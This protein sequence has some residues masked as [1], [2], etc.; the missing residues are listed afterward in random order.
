M[1]TLEKEKDEV[2]SEIT[3][4]LVGISNNIKT[5][6]EKI[7]ECSLIDQNVLILGETGTGK[8]IV[9]QQ[10]HQQSKRYD[11]EL[12]AV[13]VP[14]LPPDLIESELFGSEKGGYTGA[15]KDKAGLLQVANN[16]T[17]FL[18]EIGD[19]PKDLQ[20]KLLRPIEQKEFYPIGSSTPVE[21][22]FRVISAT[23]QSP[24]KLRRD[25]Y[26]RLAERTI[27]IL[28]LK[29]RRDDILPLIEHFLTMMGKEFNI[30]NTYWIDLHVLLMNPWNGNVRELKTLC[31]NVKEE[32]LG[33]ERVLSFDILPLSIPFDNDKY[34]LPPPID[35]LDPKLDPKDVLQYSW[36]FGFLKLAD[37]NQKIQ[38]RLQNV[39]FWQNT[40]SVIMD[41]MVDV[42]KDIVSNPRYEKVRLKYEQDKQ[43]KAEKER[44][45]LYKK[46]FP[47]RQPGEQDLLNLL[48]KNY[49][50]KV[51]PSPS[52][53]FTPSEDQLLDQLLKKSMTLPQLQKR[54]IAKFLEKNPVTKKRGETHTA[55][56][57]Q[58]GIDP[59]TLKKHIK[60]HENIG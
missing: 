3:K 54:Y 35:F 6:R 52:T 39:S 21:S 8:E 13:N 37:I 16:S 51:N 49:D 20:S 34:D 50:K 41:V 22:N 30:Q 40:E 24:D 47:E 36:G 58:L 43:R 56:A 19:M 4:V 18:D 55:R 45:E 11:K 44:R 33:N 28:P 25:L 38:S 31:E 53:P 48:L 1:K 15:V 7:Y 23:N 29:D 59:L 10:I 2:I 42:A 9:A 32:P 14:G 17:V 57:K 46:N 27:K 5:V 26:Y 60:N 12:I